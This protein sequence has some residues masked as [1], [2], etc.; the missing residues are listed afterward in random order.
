LRRGS[1]LPKRRRRARIA[2]PGRH[3][4]PPISSRMRRPNR[5]CRRT[6]RPSRRSYRD[7][8]SGPTGAS[9]ASATPEKSRA[10]TSASPASPTRSNACAASRRKRR[11]RRI[12]GQERQ[13]TL[14]NQGR[15]SAANSSPSPCGPSWE[16]SGGIARRHRQCLGMPPGATVTAKATTKE[17]ET[18]GRFVAPICGS[19]LPM[20]KDAT[21]PASLQRVSHHAT[22]SFA[23][24]SFRSRAA[25]RQNSA[26]RSR[27]GRLRSSM[28]LMARGFSDVSGG[29]SL[30]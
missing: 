24:G 15:D 11:G 10:R 7:A 5:P 3:C 2:Q 22:S 25:L 19:Q 27:R 14:L 6:I 20:P 28:S 8:R 17:A 12:D 1:A 21:G 4:R 16:R 9:P 23:A 29:A 26:S 18:M 30:P 13:Y